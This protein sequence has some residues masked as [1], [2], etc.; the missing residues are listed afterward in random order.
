MLATNTSSA[1]GQD[2]SR[3]SESTPLM[4]VSCSSSN[5]VRRS[6]TGSRLAG[7]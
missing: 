1:S 7:M 2:P 4:M 5:S 6:I 3:A